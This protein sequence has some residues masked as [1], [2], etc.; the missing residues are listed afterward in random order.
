MLALLLGASILGAGLIIDMALEDDDDANNDAD[1]GTDTETGNEDNGDLID[2]ALSGNGAEF[3][4]TELNERIMGTNGADSV[5]GGAGNDILNGL[6]GGDILLP[7]AGDD[8]VYG[9]GGNDQ[10]GTSEGDDRLFGEDGDDLIADEDGV[11]NSGNDFMRGGDGNDILISDDGFDEQR[12]DLGNDLL[13]AVDADLDEASPDLLIGGFGDDLLAGDEGDTLTGGE[14]V[15]T[16]AVIY[17]SN[18]AGPAVIT[19]FDPTSE[20][21]TLEADNQFGTDPV[22][23]IAATDDGTGSIITVDGVEF[24]VV[25]NTTPDQLVQG[26]NFALSGV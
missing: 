8:T 16:F 7:G 2:V 19:D 24:V 23:D 18:D 20:T 14:G 21:L 17:P 25:Q 13:F 26:L 6:V 5:D 15:D 1:Q 12:G 22:V 11:A 3:F 9:G 4:G 10:I